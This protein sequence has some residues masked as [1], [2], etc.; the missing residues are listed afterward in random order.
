LMGNDESRQMLVGVLSSYIT[1]I[2]TRQDFTQGGQFIDAVRASFGGS[3]DI[4]Q[5]RRDFYHNWILALLEDNALQDAEDLL[6][7]PVTKATLDDADWS[8][9]SVMVVQ[10]RAQAQ[11]STGDFVSAAGVVLDAIG[12]LGR[13]PILLQNY[14]AL[15]QNAIVQL[16]NSRKYADARALVDQGL[17]SYA[18][19]RVFQQDLDLLKKQM[20][21]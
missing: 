4:G 13:L 6:A 2:R 16:Y 14:E 21:Q 20:K 18:E 8:N 17:A 19:S 11:A 5:A 15:L 12:K 9:F 3:V 1:S 7:Q 10:R